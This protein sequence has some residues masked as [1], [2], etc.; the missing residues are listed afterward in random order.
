M[1]KTSTK[2]AVTG[3]VSGAVLAA[4]IAIGPVVHHFEPAPLQQGVSVAYFDTSG[5][6]W[7]IC[8][9]HTRGVKAGDKATPAQCDAFSLDDRIEA[10]LTVERCLPML[11]N[12]DHIGALADAAFNVGPKVVCGSTLQ[13]KA[14]VGDYFG[15]CTQLTDATGADGWPD[16][17]TKGGGKRM[18]G[19]VIRRIYDRDWCL[20]HKHA[21][22]P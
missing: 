15:M 2:L 3:A 13:R 6:V 14:Q 20:G 18:K 11:T 22:F 16:G 9:G 8:D 10:A 1:A 7:T 17:W 12:P 19:L 4:A 21:S 5:K